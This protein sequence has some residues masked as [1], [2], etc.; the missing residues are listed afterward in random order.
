MTA[1]SHGSRPN[2]KLDLARRWTN[3][4]DMK[5][6]ATR[7]LPV[8][9]RTTDWTKTCLDTDNCEHYEYPQH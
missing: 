2:I 1:T 6:K 5:W 7:L 8:S 4:N 9:G 3:A